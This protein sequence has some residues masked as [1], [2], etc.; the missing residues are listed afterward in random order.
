MGM[1]VFYFYVY[2]LSCIKQICM[3]SMTE[4]TPDIPQCFILRLSLR[5]LLPLGYTTTTRKTSNSHAVFGT[6]STV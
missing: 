4:G 2:D 5:L 3:Y 1:A 6:R